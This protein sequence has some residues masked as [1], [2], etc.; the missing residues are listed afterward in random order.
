MTIHTDQ[1]PS[2]AKAS[3]TEFW[4]EH[5]RSV[6]GPLMKATGSYSATAQEAN[7]RFL[8]NYIAPALGPHPTVAHPTYVAPCT[9]VGT[10]FNPS[11]S[12]SAKG[13]P[14]VRF[15]YDLPLPLDRASSED[16]WG[17]GKA[18]ALFRGLAA[19]LGADTQWLEY[20]MARLFLSPAETE[21]LRSKIPADLVIP[22]AMVGVAFDDAQPRLK[23]WVPTMR[24]AILEGRSSNEI[25]VE[26]LRGLSPLGSEITPAIDM[27]EAWVAASPHDPRLM[28]VGMDCGEPRDSRLK[29]YLVTTKNSWATV[30]DVMTLGGRLDDEP[31]RKQLALLREIWPYLINEPDNTRIADENWCKPE[32]MPRVGFFGLMYSLEIKPGRPTPEVKLYVPLFQY[33]ESWAIAEN[34]ME[35]VLKLLDI[36]WGHNGKYRQAMEMTFGKGNSY[37]QIFV[38]YSYSERTGGYINS[39]VSMPV[40]GVPAHAFTGDYV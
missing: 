16:P 32:R 21:A 14:T 33:A 7:L 1:P 6:I 19:A 4:S 22:S 40:K 29:I 17:E 31:T 36:D 10:L 27:V 12:L 24:R 30:Q 11:I 38:A 35:T 3:D 28:L 13:K 20:F 37:G 2:E 39:Y 9:I 8:D 25:A 34:N 23:A 18:R 15:D 5:I 26:V